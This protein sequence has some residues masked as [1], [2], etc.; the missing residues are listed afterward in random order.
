MGVAVVEVVEGQSVMPSRE[1]IEKRRQRPQG[2]GHE[3][4]SRG[5]KTT[6]EGEGEES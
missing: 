1:G 6:G 2:Q 3:I 4:A 5:H